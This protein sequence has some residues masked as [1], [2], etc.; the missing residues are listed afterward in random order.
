MI[1]FHAPGLVSSYTL[2]LLHNFIA[3]VRPAT[4]HPD[5]SGMLFKMN[6]FENARFA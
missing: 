3:M 4:A 1:I 5:Q 6:K 2:W